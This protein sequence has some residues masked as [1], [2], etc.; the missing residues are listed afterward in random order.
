MKR[1]ASLLLVVVIVATALSVTA[2]AAH[3]DGIYNGKIWK[4][5]LNIYNNKQRL[6]ATFSVAG[7]SQYDLD[8]K[9]TIKYFDKQNQTISFWSNG[10]TVW[11]VTGK[12]GVYIKS[13]SMHYIYKGLSGTI[14]EI[15]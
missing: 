3:K 6:V 12:S 8:T 7:E 1:L 4:A 5:N 14:N 13:A 11:D 15:A 10:Y 2:F 9:I